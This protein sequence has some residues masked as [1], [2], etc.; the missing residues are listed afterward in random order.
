M[1]AQFTWGSVGSVMNL[2]TTEL[3]A[4]AVNT[5]TA[6]GPEINNSSGYQLGQ[7]YLNLASAAFVAGNSLSVFIVPSN[8]TAGGSY[9]TL[10]TAAQEAL[11]NYLVGV[12]FIKGT[13]A[14]QKSTLPYVPIPLGKFKVFAMTNTGTPT[15]GA[16]GNTLDL[17]PTPTQY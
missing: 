5:L 15:L 2:L 7:L 8:D 1:T 14:A 6:L 12:V 16:T 11:A 13:T 4:L 10:G 9:P 3:N 17:Y